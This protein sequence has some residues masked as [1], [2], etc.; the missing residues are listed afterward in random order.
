MLLRRI[1]KIIHSLFLNKAL[2]VF[3]CYPENNI[4]ATQSP[5]NDVW[6]VLKHHFSF[7]FFFNFHLCVHSM[8]LA[9]QGLLLPVISSCAVGHTDKGERQQMED[10]YNKGGLVI[11]SD[12][13][14]AKMLGV[15][16]DSRWLALLSQPLAQPTQDRLNCLISKKASEESA[17]STLFNVKSATER[18]G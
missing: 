5:S 17:S 12:C 14:M 11:Y 1:I 3:L 9:K 13:S 10:H 15:C 6:V 4:Y 7:V 2:C 16:W 18:K 8:H